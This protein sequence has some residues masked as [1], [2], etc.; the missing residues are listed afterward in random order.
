MLKHFLKISFRRL[1]ADKTF[2]LIN[3]VGLV[4]GISAVFLLSKYIGFYLT[5][6]DFQERSGNLFAVHQRLSSTGETEEYSDKTYEK[7]TPLSKERFPEVKAISRYMISAETLITTTLQNGESTKFNQRGLID[8]DP[9]FIRMFTFQ[10]L[11]GDPIKAL[12]KP[13]SI[14]L[15]SSMASKYF[16][17]ENPMGKTLTAKKA[18]GNKRLWTVTGVIED[19]PANSQFQFDALQSLAGKQ[20]DQAEYGWSYPNT[21]TYLL[22]D[23]ASQSKQLAAKMT[24]TVNKLEAF[25]SVNRNIDFHLVP[26]AEEVSLTASQKLFILIGIVLLLITWINYTNLSGAK[27]L[28]RGKEFGVRRVLGSNKP[29]LVKQFMSE[30]LL[31]YALT[32]LAVSAV[33]FS[34]YP[35]LFDLS[36]GRLLPVLEFNTPINFILLVFLLLGAITSSI[37][38]SFSIYAISITGLLK[39]GKVGNSRSRGFQK[40]LVVFQFTISVIMLIGVATIYKQMEFMQNQ[41][42]GYD[43]DQVLVLKAPKDRWVGKKERIKSFKHELKSSPLITSVTSSATVPLWWPGSP[44]NFKTEKLQEQIRLIT[45]SVDEHYFNTYGLGLVSGESFKPN[46]NQSNFKKVLVNELATKRLGYAQPDAALHQK[47][48]NQK[49]GQEMQIIGVVQDHHHESLRRA[50]KPQVF[51]FNP[52][53]GFVSI[54]LGPDQNADLTAVSDAMASIEKLWNDIYPDQAFD[55]YFMDERFQQ[56]YEEEK[57]FQ[58]L[59]LGFTL[60]SVIITFLGVFGL[61]MFIS[62]RRKKEMGIR[63]VLGARPVQIIRLFSTEFIGKACLSMLIGIPLA[64]YLL[65]QWLSNFRYR[66]SFDL[67]I[68]IL[69]CICLVTLIVI[70]L[71]FESSKMAKVNPLKLLR[72][73]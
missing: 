11:Q 16:G 51:E 69:P 41:E 49:T 73:E 4:I 13:N 30:A 3:L 63:K 70:S 43:I 8:V 35:I 45:L 44:T 68:L 6:D 39:S 24:A 57:L 40:A 38:P 26:F 48:V 15:T 52:A 28:T 53:V 22:M 21:K 61:S 65:S 17:K 56:I 10:F 20:L 46:Q 62:I 66:I 50:I 36:G 34:A 47:L 25:T 58:R 14:V 60:I 71:S 18:W 23:A 33:V 42:T 37:Y 1:F 19:Y 31:L 72:D 29:A 54:K 55:Y 12:D 64:Y 5:A 9:D 2:S 27:S 59:F 32:L 7:V 67:W